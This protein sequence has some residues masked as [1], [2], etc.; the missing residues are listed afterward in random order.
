MKSFFAFL[1]YSYGMFL[2]FNFSI[3]NTYV[4]GLPLLLKADLTVIRTRDLYLL[5][6][7]TIPLVSDAVE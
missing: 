1:L 3:S 4:S 2:Y 5:S 6:P 7:L